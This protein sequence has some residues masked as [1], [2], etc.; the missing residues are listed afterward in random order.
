VFGVAVLASIFSHYGGYRTAETFSN[1]LNAAVYVGAAFVGLG[2]LAAFMIPR[3]QRSAE[4]EVL[5]P[6]LEE[7]A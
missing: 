4:V 1:G 6:T 2:A 5:R 7:A 3:R